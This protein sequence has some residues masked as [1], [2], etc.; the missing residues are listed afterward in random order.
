MRIEDLNI[1]LMLAKTQNVNRAAQLLG[2]SQSAVSK[3]LQR[4]EQSLQVNL[5]ERSRS[6]L[7]LTAAGKLLVKKARDVVGAV[8]S[9]EAD[10]SNHRSRIRGQIRI[11]TFMP[12]LP[13]TL[14]PLI[15]RLLGESDDYRLSI[16]LQISSHLINDIEQGN[17]DLALCLVGPKLPDSLSSE[18]LGQRGYVLVCRQGHPLAKNVCGLHDLAAARWLLPARPVAMRLEVEEF[19]RERGCESLDVV[20]E[21]D[22]STSL[23]IDLV[24]TTDLVTAFTM[25]TLSSIHSAH[26]GLRFHVL[27]TIAASNELR[28]IYR[29]NAPMMPGV[30]RMRELIHEAFR[31]EYE[32]AG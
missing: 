18:P 15:R 6:G 29:R 26:N 32:N 31:K 13:G 30:Q 24:N 3:V 11:G 25:E 19:F 23:L 12:M 5:A 10:F 8:H 22:I 9:L 16:S 20:V 2:V 28:L 21:T 4:L 17:L 14:L 7:R 27:H 1:F